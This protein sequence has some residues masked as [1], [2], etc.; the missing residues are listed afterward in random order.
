[1]VSVIAG[2]S[3]I[4]RLLYRVILKSISCSEKFEREEVRQQWLEL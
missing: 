1:M 4:E 2:F 3:A